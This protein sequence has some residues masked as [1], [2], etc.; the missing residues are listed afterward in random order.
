MP[1]AGLRPERGRGRAAVTQ[2]HPP[3][4]SCVSA[5]T[6]GLLPVSDG[7]PVTPVSPLIPIIP[8][9][10]HLNFPVSVGPWGKGAVRKC[11]KN[12]K[13]TPPANGET[14]S[15]KQPRTIAVQRWRGGG[16]TEGSRGEHKGSRAL[17]AG[18]P[19]SARSAPPAP[20]RP[21]EPFSRASS[22][23]LCFQPAGHHLGPAFSRLGRPRPPQPAPS[24]PPSRPAL[25]PPPPAGAAAP[26][27][28]T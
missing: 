22:F 21:V 7:P 25:L 10:P 28:S 12:P 2:G 11:A 3:A 8:I 14:S 6:A 24:Q 17:A 4:S 16:S 15:P 20:S 1:R 26:R 27:R 13:K 5:E 9:I 19:R 18:S 23:I